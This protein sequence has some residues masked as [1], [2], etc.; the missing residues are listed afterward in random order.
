MVISV[1]I[2]EPVKT[3]A[4]LVKLIIDSDLGTLALALTLALTLALGLTPCWEFSFQAREKR[5]AAAA[6]RYGA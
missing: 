4:A 2:N 1:P 3:K 6:A 5:H